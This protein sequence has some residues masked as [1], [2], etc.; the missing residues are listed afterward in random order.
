MKE[1]PITL[2]I[3]ATVLFLVSPAASA[4]DTSTS[5]E[6]TKQL[7]LSREISQDLQEIKK[8]LSK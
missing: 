7:E 4:S 2:A 6:L 8:L 1:L 5:E 3:L